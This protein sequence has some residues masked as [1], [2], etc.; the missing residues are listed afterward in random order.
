MYGRGPYAARPYS[1]FWLIAAAGGSFVVAWAHGANVVIRYG[2][3]T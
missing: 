3:A 1:G 2:Q